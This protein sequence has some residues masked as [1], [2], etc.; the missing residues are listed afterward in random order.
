ML[1]LKDNP[2]EPVEP[3]PPMPPT[4][5][6]AVIQTIIMSFAAA[7]GQLISQGAMQ[8]LSERFSKKD[9]TKEGGDISLTDEDF[10]L[11][12][13]V[14]AFDIAGEMRSLG[15]S[16][17]DVMKALNAFDS[18]KTKTQMQELFASWANA[19][20]DY[21]RVNI[22]NTIKETSSERSK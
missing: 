9:L 13:E 7:T 6:H 22:W 19:K 15:H 1:K 21:E 8:F 16:S 18:E 10:L 17:D 5:G 3:M 14:N 12:R 20:T 2:I 4:F 11:D